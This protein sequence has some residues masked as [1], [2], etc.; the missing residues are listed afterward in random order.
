VPRPFI[1]CT[2]PVFRDTSRFRVSL[3]TVMGV[4]PR[5]VSRTLAVT[6]CRAQPQD[7]VRLKVRHPTAS[8][9]AFA[10]DEASPRPFGLHELSD[11]INEHLRLG[12]DQMTDRIFHLRLRWNNEEFDS[13]ASTYSR[14]LAPMLWLEVLLPNRNLHQIKCVQ[15]IRKYMNRF[16]FRE[17]MSQ[18]YAGEKLLKD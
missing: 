8:T 18:V 4:V 13:R 5:V 12:G 6:G 15:G 1:R 10:A 16:K 3:V 14:S 9:P 7:A 17:I 2:T 11:L